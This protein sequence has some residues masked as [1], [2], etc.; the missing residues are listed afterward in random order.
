MSTGRHTSHLAEM[1]LPSSS[2]DMPGEDDDSPSVRRIV[3]LRG[4]SLL[5]RKL[6]HFHPYHGSLIPSKRRKREMTPAEKKDALYWDK[7]RKNNEAAK[8]SREKRRFNDLMLESQLLALSEENAQLRAELLSLQYHMGLARGADI[9]QSL[10]SNGPLPCPTQPSHLHPSLWDLNTGVPPSNLYPCW[11]QHS[12]CSTS[13]PNSSSS[14]IL[15]HKNPQSSGTIAPCTL[16]LGQPAEQSKEGSQGSGS[17]ETDPA[18]HQQVSSSNDPNSEQES[19]SSQAASSSSPSSLTSQPPRNWLLNETNHTTNQPNNLLMQ[20]GSS[21]LRPSP[22]H[23]RWPQ[24]FSLPLRDSEG[25]R[26]GINSL[27][28]LNGKFSMLSAEISQL[29]RYLRPENA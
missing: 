20:W 26:H 4:P 16:S 3:P 10:R 19:S 25:S 2:A 22:L 7:R 29:R 24:P 28:N 23:A 17:S 18:A 13:P 8:R 6:F 14:Q 1:C 21:C 27:W 5:A 12:Y 15:L 11:P 9:T